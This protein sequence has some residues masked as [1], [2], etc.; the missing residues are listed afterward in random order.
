MACCV[1]CWLMME[2]RLAIHVSAIERQVSI[3]LRV[4][5]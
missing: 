5:L 1:A 2:E 3:E 4:N